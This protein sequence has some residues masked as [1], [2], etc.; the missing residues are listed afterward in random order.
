M[1]C[2]EMT[3]EWRELHKKELSDLYSSPIIVRAIKSRIMRWLGHVAHMGERRG[4]YRV[5]V[6]N[7]EGKRPL[8]RPRR[9][10]ENNIMMGLQEM[11]C[12]GYGLDRSAST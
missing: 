8:G 5:L 6:G 9:I 1:K 3:G 12:G 11:G 4:M 2:G 7:P 10:W